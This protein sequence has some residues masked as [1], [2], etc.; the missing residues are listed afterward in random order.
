MGREK[1]SR[2]REGGE[3]ERTGDFLW[4]LKTGSYSVVQDERELT[5]L[6]P[7]PPKCQDCRHGLPQLHF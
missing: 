4:F 3:G 1:D 6:L 7:H 2:G 5:V